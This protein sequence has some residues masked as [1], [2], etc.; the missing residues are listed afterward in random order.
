[1]NNDLITVIIPCYNV[2]KYLK[3]CVDS[4]IN[5]T[6]QN[7]EVILV[8][9]G[10]TDTTAQLCDELAKTDKRIKVLHKV[11]GG[12]SNARNTGFAVATGNYVTFLD[13]DDWLEANT[14][15]TAYNK[16]TKENL[17]LVIWGYTADF[18]DDNE[19][20]IDNRIFAVSGICEYSTINSVFLQ[21]STLGISGYVWNKL[22]KTEIIRENNLSFENG[23]SLVEDILFNSLYFCKC[24]RIEFIDYVGNHYMQRKHQ[25]LGTKSYENILDLK[26]IG[27]K[28]REN[29]LKY[30][31]I[32]NNNIN[33]IMSFFY[34]DAFK[35]AITNIK[36][37]PNISKKEKH[38]KIKL[39]LADKNV[40][41]IVKKAQNVSIKQKILVIAARLRL[42]TILIKI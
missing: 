32:S 40:Q 15:K 5:Q 27:C 20:V 9:D 36:T 28:A 30:F 13:S 2:E 29:I 37:E 7:L 8:D 31:G 16:M 33:K 3:K 25:T 17:D 22:Y 24:R 26:L 23:I 14:I 10:S 21:K 19:K 12:L 38:Q 4:I 34:Y 6:H 41:F 35:S 42:S 11:N 1:M 18:V 39:F